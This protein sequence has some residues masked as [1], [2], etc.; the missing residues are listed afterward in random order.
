MIPETI[1]ISAA[2][3]EGYDALSAAAARVLGTR[4]FDPAAP[5]LATERQRAC[6]LQALSCLEQALEAIDMG[7]TLD[8]VTVCIDGALSALLEL[9]G[10]KANEAIVDEVFS[11]FCVGK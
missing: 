6:C 9:T 11:T 10:E 4:D 1:F 3:G 5:L 8:A 2:Q 7:M